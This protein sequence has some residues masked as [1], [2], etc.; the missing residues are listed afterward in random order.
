LNCGDEDAID[1]EVS[2]G[3]Y[4][5]ADLGAFVQQGA[6][7]GALRLLGTGGSPCVAAVILFAGE[8]DFETSRHSDNASAVSDVEPNS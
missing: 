1:A 7:Q 5:I 2:I 3:S 4:D 6:L 8:L